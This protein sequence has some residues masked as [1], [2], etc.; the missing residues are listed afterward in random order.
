MGSGKFSAISMVRGGFA[1]VTF[2]AILIT[3]GCVGTTGKGAVGGGGSSKGTVA[4][5]VSPAA[6]DFGNVAVGSGTMETVKIT[7]DGT[8]SLTIS[9]FSVTGTGY[10]IGG[11]SAPMTL[12][13]G[14]TA[15]LNVSYT[16]ASSGAT[17]GVVTITSNADDS[18]TAVPLNGGG[19]TASL[20]LSPASLN[21]GAVTVGTSATQTVKITNTGSSAAK[22]S[23]ISV[24]GADI[25]VS[26]VSTPATIAAGQ[27]AQ[28]T[29]TFKPTSTST[30][31][32]AMAVTSNAS[33][34]PITAAWT[35]SGSESSFTVTPASVSFG[36]VTVGSNA[37]QTIKLANT[38][39]AAVT[40]SKLT[41]SGTGM[42]ASGLSLPYTLGAGKSTTFTA[43]FKPTSAASD[44]GSIAISSSATAQ[45]VP[46]SGKGVSSNATLT[47]SSSSISFGNVKVGVTDSGSVTVTSSG[48]AN[49]NI[50]SASV[51]GTGYSLSGS[52]GSET[53]A[54]NQ[55]QTYTV[56]FDPKASG[57]ASG[58]L[59]INSNAPNS[60]MK[61]SLA[62]TGT[63]NS[64]DTSHT[65]ALNWSASK[66]SVIGYNVY[67]G[68]KSSGPYTK[69]NG[70]VDTATSYSDASV[71]DGTEYYYVVT[72]VNSEHVESSDSNQVAVTIPSN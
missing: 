43:E 16:A 37:T 5:N 45:S 13:A 62:G 60:P 18:P 8:A 25:S 66:S 7:N 70:S 58:V 35:G 63:S 31:S 38:G 40:I 14:Q 72:S 6:L 30:V 3:S 39:N 11:L 68:T 46:L 36:D 52:G 48:N 1:A 28:V 41:T 57:G 59:T 4:M 2:A 24:T 50:S 10:Q 67:R 42:S 19:E 69:L 23:E 51:S 61:I 56:N 64:P 29:A 9:K 54:P 71:S 53:L 15:T 47:S 20:S 26:G 55:T 65:V 17:T 21:F 33:S 22:I 27:S 44:S 49:V 32:G 12:S 34:A